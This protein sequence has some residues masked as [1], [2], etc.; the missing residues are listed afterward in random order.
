MQSD[1][2][3]RGSTT[4]VHDGWKLDLH[5]DHAFIRMACA[6]FEKNGAVRRHRS[7]EEGDV[8]LPSETALRF[9]GVSKFEFRPRDADKSFAEDNRLF[10]AGYL[11]HDNWRKDV[12]WIEDEPAPTGCRLSNSCQ[13]RSLY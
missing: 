13:V 11:L 5:I 8:P 6:V 7:N 2:R 3:F 9:C 12:F 10:S 4:L 1:C